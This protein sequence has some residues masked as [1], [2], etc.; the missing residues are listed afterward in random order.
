MRDWTVVVPRDRTEANFFTFS[1]NIPEVLVDDADRT[2][3]VTVSAARIDS[4]PLV[5]P[6]LE[7]RRTYV[8]ILANWVSMKE[9]GREARAF[10]SVS[11]TFKTKK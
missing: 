1:Q 11:Q 7:Y 10:S 6:I 2:W 9:V 8:R 5:D 3:T 4:G